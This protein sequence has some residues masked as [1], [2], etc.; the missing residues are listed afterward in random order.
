M[1]IKKSIKELRSRGYRV[2][3]KQRKDGGILIKSINGRKFTGAKGN[4]QAR[5]IL[6]TR[7]SEA[8]SYQLHRLNPQKGDNWTRPASQ[9]RKPLPEAL[10]RELKNVQR[11]WRKGS[12][13]VLSHTT[14]QGTI[15]R[16]NLRYVYET[17]G[18]QEAWL[19]LRKAK[20]Y[21]QGYAYEENVKWLRDTIKEQ[22]IDKA[23]MYGFDA[24][25]FIDI[26]EELGKDE[27]I[28]NFQEEWINAIHDIYYDFTKR[29][30]AFD[31]Y[32]IDEAVRQIKIILQGK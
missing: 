19:K 30:M 18:E 17:Y 8:R 22:I 7:L 4:A 10:S 21:A 25:G 5:Q 28:E 27:V 2:T 3:Y 9:K 24:S 6:G 12:G 32:N 11:L 26:Y 16:G 15:S 23:T 29:G 14:I 31:Q 20:R 1:T 13:K